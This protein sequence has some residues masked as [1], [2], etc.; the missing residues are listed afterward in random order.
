VGNIKRIVLLS[1]F[2]LSLISGQDSVGQQD[3]KITEAHYHLGKYEVVITQQKRLNPDKLLRSKGHIDAGDL[4]IWCAAHIEI[5]Q[6]G[7]IID[8]LDFNN[9][10]PLGW[11]HGLHLPKKQESS[12]HL[13]LV[14]YGDYDD[15][16]LVI[17]DEGKFFNLGG[18]SYRIFL[19]RYLI[20]PRDMADSPWNVTVFDLVENKTLITLGWGEPIKVIQM[21]PANGMAQ[22]IKIY[23]SEADLF[24]SI[25]LVNLEYQKT[26]GRPLYFY[27]IDL[28]TGKISDAVFDE[29]KHK[30][31]IIDYSNIDMSND[32]ECK[33]KI[34]RQP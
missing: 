18:G 14:K 23:T 30:E 10:N 2:S 9:M 26:I 24:A 20:S 1:L 22:I 29:K 3:F 16:T 25:D 15:R 12:K 34:I 17:N 7:N 27:K 5:S 4:P 32:C 33:D 11:H 21:C 6:N 31:F 28:E 13:I 19:N 8:R